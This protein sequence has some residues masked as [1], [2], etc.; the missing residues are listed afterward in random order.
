MSS[1]PP[2]AGRRSTLA[3]AEGRQL[4]GCFANDCCRRSFRRAELGKRRD[5]ARMSWVQA[6]PRQAVEREYHG[7]TD[8][9]RCR[10]SVPVRWVLAWGH[11]TRAEVARSVRGQGFYSYVGWSV[12]ARFIPTSLGDSI[13]PRDCA[14]LVHRGDA[15]SRKATICADI[16]SDFHWNKPSLNLL[17]Q[18]FCVAGEVVTA[19][20]VRLPAWAMIV[21]PLLW[22]GE[23]H[24]PA[25][26]SCPSSCAPAAGQAACRH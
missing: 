25:A 20:Q 4:D 9:D 17:P 15:R 7:P 8:Q 24:E 12:F 22:S 16:G 26:S 21:R 18:C 13:D 11:A 23:V 10:W 19:H 1:P 5:P 3:R 2:R 14:T 6:R